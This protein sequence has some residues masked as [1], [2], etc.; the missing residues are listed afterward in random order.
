MLNCWWRSPRCLPRLDNTSRCPQRNIKP[1]CSP[2]S[3]GTCAKEQCTTTLHFKSRFTANSQ[4]NHSKFLL[5]RLCCLLLRFA[6]C[7]DLM[8]YDHTFLWQYLQKTERVPC[9]M[10]SDKA[11]ASFPPPVWYHSY[12]HLYTTAG[13]KSDLSVCQH[14]LMHHSLVLLHTL[15]SL[16]YQG[17][18]PQ[19]ISQNKEKL[20]SLILF[21]SCENIAQWPM[22]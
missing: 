16:H 19:R 4:Q 6:F 7:Y 3:L 1:A 14:N 8:E 15:S 22:T 21:P 18:R 9:Q 5:L 10:V 12:Q 11:Q 13:Y 2:S 17:L 20:H